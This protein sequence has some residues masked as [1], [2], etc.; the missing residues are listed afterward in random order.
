MIIGE[1]ELLVVDASYLG[2]RD[3]PV[4]RSWAPDVVARLKAADLGLSVVT[5]AATAQTLGVPV[6]TCDKAFLRMESLDIEVVHLPAR[7]P[8]E[9]GQVR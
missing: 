2:R 8:A 3:R 6:V 9:V 5:I 1:R 4:S 7:I